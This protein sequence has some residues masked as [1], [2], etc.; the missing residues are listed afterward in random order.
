MFIN[1]E[2]GADILSKCVEKLYLIW[3]A[4]KARCRATV[5]PAILTK[6]TAIMP[7]VMGGIKI[8]SKHPII[9]YTKK[10]TPCTLSRA[11]HITYKK[12]ISCCFVSWP[13]AIIVI[14]TAK[15]AP[16]WALRKTGNDNK[17]EI[18][19]MHI[20]FHQIDILMNEFVSL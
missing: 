3:G 17:F 14:R 12:K 19:L 9:W 2:H 4:S 8:S 7:H 11:N 1:I 10:F 13:W 15:E 20:V 18:Y 6:Y 5:L 16:Y